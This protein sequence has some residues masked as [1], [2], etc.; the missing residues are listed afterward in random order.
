MSELLEQGTEQGARRCVVI[1]NESFHRPV[2]S[3]EV[4]IESMKG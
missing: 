3:S 4:G 2:W 1:G